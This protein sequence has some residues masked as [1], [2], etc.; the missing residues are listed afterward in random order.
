[1]LMQIAEPGQSTAKEPCKPRVVGIDLGTSRSSISASNG[2][3]HVI[4]SYVGWPLDMVARKVLKKPVLIGRDALENRTMVDLH[5]PLEQGLIKEGSEKDEAAVRERIAA[6]PDATLAEL[7]VWLAAE[8]AVMVGK[9]VLWK[10]LARLGLTLKKSTS[11][12]R[13]RI[14]RR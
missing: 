14:A 11:G 10:G 5:R 8:H 4:E 2:Q 13:S 1:M 3:R 7:C 12:R 9:T 6:E